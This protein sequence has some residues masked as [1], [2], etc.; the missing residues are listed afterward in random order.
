MPTHFVINYSQA[1]GQMAKIVDNAY[2]AL[3]RATKSQATT[4]AAYGNGYADKIVRD[5]AAT[6]YKTYSNV[7]RQNWDAILH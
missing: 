5:A 7:I 3:V 1:P 2:L 6:W 4:A